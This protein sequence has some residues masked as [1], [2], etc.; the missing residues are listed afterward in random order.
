MA[1]IVSAALFPRRG[2][3]SRRD[4][5]TFRRVGY[6]ADPVGLL[7][8]RRLRDFFKLSGGYGFISDLQSVGEAEEAKFGVGMLP[9]LNFYFG[10]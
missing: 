7:G 1:P 6:S 9:A 10:V 3:F 8:D 4:P 2:T 5:A